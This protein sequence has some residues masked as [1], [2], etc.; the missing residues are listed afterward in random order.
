MR[1]GKN[2]LQIFFDRDDV[3]PWPWNLADEVLTKDIADIADGKKISI[4]LEEYDQGHIFIYCSAEELNIFAQ[5]ILEKLLR[6]KAFFDATVENVNMKVD[7]F[8]KRWKEK[9]Q[10]SIRSGS[11]DSLVDLLA[12]Y[13]AE[14]KEVRVWGWIP[15]L[16]D[17]AGESLLTNTCI[18]ALKNDLPGRSEEEINNIF[19]LFSS[20]RTFGEVQKSEIEKWKLVADMGNESFQKLLSSADDTLEGLKEKT[21]QSIDAYLE[22]FA[23]IS[24]NYEGPA[25]TLSI[26]KKSLH[27]LT[28]EKARA[29]LDTIFAKQRETFQEQDRFL[30]Q[31][32]LSQETRYVLEIVRAFITLKEYRKSVYQQSYILADRILVEIAGRLDIALDALKFLSIGEMRSAFSKT[33]AYKK[34]AQ[35]RRRGYMTVIVENGTSVFLDGDEAR[36]RADALKEEEQQIN[37][38]ELRGQV[39]YPG[40]VSGVAKIIRTV[41]DLPKMKEGDILISSSTNPDLL[42]AMKKAGAIVTEMGGI[43]CHAAI[44]AR[45]LHIPCVVGTKIAL[46]AIHD[47]D[48]LDVDATKGIVKIV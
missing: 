20:P 9:I 31:N 45:E 28:V 15:A 38:R 11:D 30:G 40:S 47:G 14:L 1:T 34:K 29:E 42:P 3:Y 13:A 32:A 21:K 19:S 33:D 43:T 8:L 10:E 7:E 48:Q 46:K 6:E 17:G 12:S 44:V 2:K 16:V 37:V 39:A 18:A 22:R 5:H 41:K 26:F 23:W 25:L 4:I 27:E 36:E 24:Y 35:Q